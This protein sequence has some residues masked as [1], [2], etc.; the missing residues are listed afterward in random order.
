[1]RSGDARGAFN[2]LNV[3]HSHEPLRQRAR[4]LA[5]HAYSPPLSDG[6]TGCR[7][8]TREG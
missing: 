1:M 8:D 7:W 2:E 6:R 3:T 5:Q 4:K